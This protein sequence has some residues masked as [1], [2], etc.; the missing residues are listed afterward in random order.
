[1]VLL[2]AEICEE[3]KAT[4]TR[5]LELDPADAGFTDFFLITSCSNTRQT[6][7]VSEEIELRM[8]RQFGTYAKSVEGRRTGEWILLDYIDFVVHIFTE[9]TR[10][11]YD[12]E[13]LRKSARTMGPAE[14]SAALKQKTA[15]VR[16]KASEAGAAL[17]LVAGAAKKAPKKA[18]KKAPVKPTGLA[19]AEPAQAPA[20]Q[21]A[22]KA[23]AKKAPAKKAP[24]KKAAA[25]KA[26]AKKAPAKKAPAKKAP[27]KK[28]PAK[29]A[30]A[31]KARAGIT[32]ATQAPAQATKKAPAKK[33]PAK[34]PAAKKAIIKKSARA[35]SV[36][37]T[38]PK[39]LGSGAR[40]V[41]QL[42]APKAK[43]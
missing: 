22:K 12:I 21:A 7:A 4:D 5:I 17:A 13:R 34:K 9:E 2:A 25:K 35:S 43:K 10:E 24:A 15:A 19:K 16:N 1:M 31:K 6:G 30:P 23:P 18:A 33:A 29:K 27:A 42:A 11:Y 39:A 41:K 40:P 28:A 38:S 36:E 32:P 14:L 3:K 26:P 8:K 20:K 37:D